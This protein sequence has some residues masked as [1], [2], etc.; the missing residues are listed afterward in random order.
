M[1]MDADLGVLRRDGR[2]DPFFDGAAADRLVIRRCEE[3]GRWFA[4]DASGCFSCGGDRLTWAPA[5]GTATLVSWAVSHPRPRDDGA[6]RPPVLLGLVELTEGPWLHTRLD[7]LDRDMPSE[8]LP[9]TATFRHPEEGEAY[10]VFRPA[11]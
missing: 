10:L 6:A 11:P 7:G 4:P 2:T 5:A 8:G 3:C 9:L 1:T